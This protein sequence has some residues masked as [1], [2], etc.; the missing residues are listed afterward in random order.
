[1]ALTGHIYHILPLKCPNKR[2]FIQAHTANKTPATYPSYYGR[3][4][5]DYKKTT[6]STPHSKAVFI[7]PT[8]SCLIQLCCHLRKKSN[9]GTSQRRF[10]WLYKN[11]N[12]DQSN[13]KPPITLVVLGFAFIV[14]SLMLRL[15]LSF[16]FI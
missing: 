9:E 10:L 7:H 4:F 13:S 6:G 14:M 16:G 5:S 12:K 8:G 2:C 1:M 11:S 15:A 3:R